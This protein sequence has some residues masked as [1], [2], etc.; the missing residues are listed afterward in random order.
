[1]KY[2]TLQRRLRLINVRY[3][4]SEEGLTEVAILQKTG[5]SP[6]TVTEGA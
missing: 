2:S 5:T 3:C 6:T 1:M 4:R